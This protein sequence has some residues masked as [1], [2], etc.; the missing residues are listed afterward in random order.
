MILPPR[1]LLVRLVL[2]SAIL[3]WAVWK[4]RQ[5]SVNDLFGIAPPPDEVVAAP[6]PVALP[7]PAPPAP[8]TGDAPATVDVQAAIATMD[9]TEAAVLPCGAVGTLVVELDTT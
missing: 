4:M 9:A 6:E 5:T 8:L 2:W 3:V 7:R 1:Q